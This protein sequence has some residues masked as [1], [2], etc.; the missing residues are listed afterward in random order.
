[1][2]QNT[3]QPVHTQKA[4][5]N[6]QQKRQTH[7]DFRSNNPREVVTPKNPVYLRNVESKIKD[8]IRMTR[9]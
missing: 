4:S 1:M 7:A 6:T 9:T 8:Q 2:V 5:K 3:S